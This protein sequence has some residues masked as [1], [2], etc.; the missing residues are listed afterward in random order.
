MYR[1]ENT[2]GTPRMRSHIDERCNAEKSYCAGVV[3]LAWS[4][5][6]RRLSRKLFIAEPLRCVQ[7]PSRITLWVISQI[8]QQRQNR[9]GGGFISEHTERASSKE[10]KKWLKLGLPVGFR[11]WT[12]VG[13]ES[14]AADTHA[15]VARAP[16]QTENARTPPPTHT[17]LRTH[18][19]LP[20][21]TCPWHRSVRI[22]LHF[23]HYKLPRRG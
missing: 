10:C 11:A 1:A 8:R 22:P 14:C 21:A 7:L 6:S 12:L 19:R 15:A 23:R 17:R 5:L 2:R 13:I 3:E 16:S 18:A 4:P 9:Y 20:L